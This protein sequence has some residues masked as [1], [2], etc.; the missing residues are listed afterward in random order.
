MVVLLFASGVPPFSHP[1]ADILCVRSM[2][3]SSM[4]IHYFEDSVC[5]LRSPFTVCAMVGA[6]INRSR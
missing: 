6:V 1:D 3:V 5:Q 4:Y 2:R